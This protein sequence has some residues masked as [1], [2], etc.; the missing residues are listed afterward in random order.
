M[1][2]GSGPPNT[3]LNSY[4][5]ILVNSNFCFDF[6]PSI[7]FYEGGNMEGFSNGIV[8]KKFSLKFP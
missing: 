5:N 3:L 8:L 1:I 7:I 4:V 2:T 6:I